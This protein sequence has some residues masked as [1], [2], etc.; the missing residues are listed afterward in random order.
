MVT[1]ALWHVLESSCFSFSAP[2][3]IVSIATPVGFC[4]EITLPTFV[5]CIF[6]VFFVDK[7][8]VCLFGGFNAM[9]FLVLL[10]HLFLL[11]VKNKF[12]NNNGFL[13]NVIGLMQRDLYV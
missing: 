4:V 7:T 12:N 3:D 6:F 9:N 13:R 1:R 11:Y 8:Q 5:L 2:L 10:F